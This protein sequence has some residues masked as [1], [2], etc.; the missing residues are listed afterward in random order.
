[1]I[2][3]QFFRLIRKT[4]EM[5]FFYVFS[6]PD[7]P[8]DAAPLRMVTLKP[9]LPTPGINIAPVILS[10]VCDRHCSNQAKI[11]YRLAS[12]VLDSQK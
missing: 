8:H 10:R 12:G 5:L 4:K 2:M 7:A 11:A 3:H 1:M 9:T 6:L